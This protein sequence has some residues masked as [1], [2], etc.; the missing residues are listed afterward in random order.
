MMTEA[1]GDVIGIDWRVNLASAW[2]TVGHDRAV[3]GNP[4]PT[5]PARR[6]QHNRRTRNRSA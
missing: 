2:Q 5:H 4:R 3:Q 1:G 6:P